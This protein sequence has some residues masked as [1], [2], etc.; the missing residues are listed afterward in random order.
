MPPTPA[1]PNLSLIDFDAQPARLL[2]RA[3]KDRLAEQ[4]RFS[5][6][7]TLVIKETGTVPFYETAIRQRWDGEP[8]DYELA[9]IGAKC[10]SMFRVDK[11]VSEEQARHI[12]RRYDELVDEYVKAR[13]AKYLQRGLLE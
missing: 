5:R 1:T 12:E 2:S 6:E 8:C 10:K 4:L 7:L 11:P 9:E 13:V 3:E